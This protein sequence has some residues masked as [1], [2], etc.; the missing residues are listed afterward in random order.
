[1]E[2]K[3]RACSKVERRGTD[4]FAPRNVDQASKFLRPYSP[5]NKRERQGKGRLRTFVYN[6]PWKSD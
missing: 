4:P 3:V 1:M 2:P 5:I 6:R